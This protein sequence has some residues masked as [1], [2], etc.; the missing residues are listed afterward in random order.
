MGSFACPLDFFL[1]F[2][3]RLVAPTTCGMTG[4][5]FSCI[6]YDFNSIPTNI[7][8]AFELSH[9]RLFWSHF[10]A[11]I[12]LRKHCFTCAHQKSFVH[13]NDLWGVIGWVSQTTDFLMVFGV[14]EKLPIQIFTSLI[15]NEY[16][17]N[18]QQRKG[19][20]RLFNLLSPFIHNPALQPGFP[21]QTGELPDFGSGSSLGF[22]C[23]DLTRAC[24]FGTI[25][26]SARGSGSEV[27][28]FHSPLLAQLGRSLGSPCTA[29]NVNQLQTFS[30]HHHLA[31]IPQSWPWLWTHNIAQLLPDSCPPPELNIS[32]LEAVST[33]YGICL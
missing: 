12:F 23:Q 3:R 2:L 24:G 32:K 10:S 30:N 6:C 26:G 25:F 28:R 14:F 27:F 5:F 31:S 15:R 8:P 22:A 29:S 11:T 19:S 21:A 9:A 18:I 7:F 1:S 13:E 16:C 20:L 17:I 33:P 4:T